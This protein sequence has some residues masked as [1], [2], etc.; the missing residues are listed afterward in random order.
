MRC[1]ENPCISSLNFLDG[2]ALESWYILLLNTLS[3]PILIICTNAVEQVPD[4]MIK[5]ADLK[6]IKVYSLILINSG[7]LGIV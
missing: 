2:K 6:K 4:P 1:M 3:P 7:A 5:A